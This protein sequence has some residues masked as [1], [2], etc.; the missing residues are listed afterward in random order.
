VA[1]LTK[2]QFELWWL[3]LTIGIVEIA[4]AFWVAGSFNQKTILLVVSVGAIALIRGVTELFLAF[5]LKGGPPG[6]LA[7]A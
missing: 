6:R 1:A 3:Q 2:S 7:V 4:I 5:K